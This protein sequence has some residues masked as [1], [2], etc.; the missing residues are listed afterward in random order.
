[1]RG[2]SRRRADRCGRL[3][4]LEELAHRRRDTRQ[5][6][7][8]LRRHAHKRRSVD[9]GQTSAADEQRPLMVG[10]AGVAASVRPLSNRVH[11]SFLACAGPPDYRR[12]ARPGGRFV[13]HTCRCR[14]VLIV[15]SLAEDCDGAGAV[16]R[17]WKRAGPR[18]RRLRRHHGDARDR[19]GQQL[20]E[21]ARERPADARAHLE[22]GQAGDGAG[23]ARPARRRR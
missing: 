5:I 8:A 11:R 22:L 19:L 13:L 6:E 12:A 2:K 20:L 10:R 14:D 17:I 3:A 21:G 4:Q 18:A 7:D 15:A 9:S 16:R 23:R 1:M